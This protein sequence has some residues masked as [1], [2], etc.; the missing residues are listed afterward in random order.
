MSL[1]IQ[2]KEVKLMVFTIIKQTFKEF[3]RSASSVLLDVVRMNSKLRKEVILNDKK[4]N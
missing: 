4:S 3:V 2:Q 1:Q